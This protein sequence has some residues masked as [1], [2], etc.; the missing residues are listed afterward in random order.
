METDYKG[1]LSNQ[2]VCSISTI[3]EFVAHEG[4]LVID[5]KKVKYLPNADIIIGNI[6]ISI[7]PSDYVGK[8][9]KKFSYDNEKNI[10]VSLFVKNNG[11]ND[12]IVLGQPLLR[13]VCTSF[14]YDQK[15]IGF[16]QIISTESENTSTCVTSL[17]IVMLSVIYF[18]NTSVL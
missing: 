2:G 18:S 12:S 10:C 9:G 13:K 14:D 6:T 7:A 8:I 11:S 16:A 15:M 5:C 4:T 3:L 1:W 17:L